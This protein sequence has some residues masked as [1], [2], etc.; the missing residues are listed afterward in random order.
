[1]GHP[2]PF[3]TFPGPHSISHLSTTKAVPKT[4]PYHCLHPGCLRQFKRSYDLCRH[5]AIHRPQD[6]LYDCPNRWCGRVGEF[7]FRRKDHLHEHLRMMHPAAKIDN[8][9]QGSFDLGQPLY[10]CGSKDCYRE[11]TSR[12]E[13]ENHVES[14]AP[15]GP[16]QWAEYRRPMH[17]GIAPRSTREAR[18]DDI[19]GFETNSDHLENVTEAAKTVRSS[20]NTLGEFSPAVLFERS[21][22]YTK[23]GISTDLRAPCGISNMINCGITS[24]GTFSGGDNTAAGH[25]SAELPATANSGCL[26]PNLQLQDNGVIRSES[27]QRIQWQCHCGHASYDDFIEL[28]PGAVKEYE[29][30][31]RNRTNTRNSRSANA[32]GNGSVMHNIPGWNRLSRYVNNVIKAET[33]SLPRYQLESVSVSQPQP[34]T[35]DI[36]ILYLLL[37]VPHQKFATKLLQLDLTKVTSDQH[38][39]SLLRGN[40]FQMRGRFK[41]CFSLKSLRSIKFVQFE[42]YRSDLVDIQKQDDLP[43][44]DLKDT[45][46]YNP[47]PAD[48]IPPVGE[49]HMLHLCTHPE[50][51]DETGILFD[52][53]PKK[54][55]ER[56]A[57]CP[58]KG[59]SLGWGIYFIEGWHISIVTLL[60]YAILVLVSFVFFVCWAVLEQDVQGASGV[61]TYVLAFLT[62]GTGSVQAAFEFQ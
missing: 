37:C 50:C 43:P 22:D 56:L 49:N 30:M 35:S 55:K 59:S 57:V 46:R 28:R 25:A 51:A 6:L 19:P 54:L 61:A 38:L 8:R 39:F 47:V 10:V 29:S 12:P 3:E 15:K 31:L 40:Y 48:K 17:L 41:N 62:L 36:E 58:Q 7:G 52:R 18:A 23:R 33:P 42:M 60:A 14:C 21:E 24:V 16:R 13:W 26:S 53:I 11:F 20:E 1:M 27:K 45:Y 2:D 32:G 4:K 44:A 5:S 9:P 34:S